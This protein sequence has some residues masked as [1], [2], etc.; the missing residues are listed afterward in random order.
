MPIEIK[1]S[2]LKEIM[3]DY[4]FTSDLQGTFN[5]DT[6]LVYGAKAALMALAP[7][8][9]IIM[10][11]YA[12]VASM[13]KLAGILGVGTSTVADEIHRIRREMKKTISEYGG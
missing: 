12:H 8:D 6:D 4:D 5:D 9:R 10:T 13:P 7:P 11:L 1:P 3:E 2:R